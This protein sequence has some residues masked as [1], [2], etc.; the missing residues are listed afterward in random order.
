MS[1]KTIM[2]RGVITGARPYEG[3]YRAQLLP[4][5]RGYTEPFVLGECFHVHRT[6]RAA[7]ACCERMAV[8]MAE[9]HGVVWKDPS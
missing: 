7:I 8:E 4:Q 5:R 6:E 2:E 3:G 9:R 1:M